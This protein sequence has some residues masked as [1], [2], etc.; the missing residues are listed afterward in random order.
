MKSLAQVAY[1][2]FRE[3]SPDPLALTWEQLCNQR[4]SR[5]AVSVW[6]HVAR[7]VLRAARANIPKPESETFRCECGASMMRGE[8]HACVKRLT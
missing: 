5:R 2:A 3:G 6:Q 8:R 7:E 4:G 1:E